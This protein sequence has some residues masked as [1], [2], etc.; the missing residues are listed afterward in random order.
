MRLKNNKTHTKEWSKQ[1]LFNIFTRLRHI[2]SYYK[3]KKDIKIF[4]YSTIKEI[5]QMHK[6]KILWI[7]HVNGTKGIKAIKVAK[8][9]K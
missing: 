8:I 4:L 3:T 1:Y 5:R 7:N 6:N 2:D 9:I